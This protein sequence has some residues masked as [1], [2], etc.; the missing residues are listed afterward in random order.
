MSEPAFIEKRKVV[1]TT[2][3]AA[4]TDPETGNQVVATHQAVDYVPTNI[5]DAY[6]ADAKA[7][8]QDVQVGED[9]DPGPGGDDGATHYPAH[10]DHP[11]A[12]GR[13]VGEVPFE[14]VEASVTSDPAVIA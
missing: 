5:L 3:V 7:K 14:V 13:T 4:G 1:M 11:D 9:H 10:L 8:W 12:D 2:V 6:V